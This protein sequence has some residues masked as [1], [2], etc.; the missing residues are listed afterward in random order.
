MAI[1][2]DLHTG[3]GRASEKKAAFIHIHF[4]SLLPLSHS[5]VRRRINK[6]NRMNL[7]SLDFDRSGAIQLDQRDQTYL[8]KSYDN[9]NNSQI[10]SASGI[11]R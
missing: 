6:V 7:S 11:E 8:P 5:A 10:E 4:L 1:R 9:N 2:C 3:G